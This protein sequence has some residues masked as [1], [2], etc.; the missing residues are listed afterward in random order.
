MSNRDTWTSKFS[1]VLA[2]IGSAIGLG[3]I[4]MFPWRLGKYGGAAFL[5]PYLLFVFALGSTG[6]IE[7]FALGR[8]QKTG[9][10]GAFTKIFKKKDL[11]FG[12][13]IG[14][15]PV[16]GL[17]G[18]F[19]FYTIVAGWILKYFLL[20][21]SGSF[22]TAGEIPNYF[23]SLA[24]QPES[25]L[26]HLLAIILTLAIVRL[27]VKKGIEKV[28]NFMMPT[29]FVIFIILVIRSLTLPGASAGIRFML[30]P[31][32]SLLLKPI[33]WVMALGQAFF[34]VS[35]GGAAMLVYG[36]YLK[37][38]ADIP[39]AAFNTVVFNTL[40]SFLAAFIIIPAVFAFNLD[41]Q[42][43]PPL[44]FI[45]IPKIF[46]QMTGGYFFG[47]LFFLSIVFAAI[48]S[49]INLMEVPV[50]ALIDQL[51]WS[52]KKSVFTVASLSFLAGI[53]LDLNMK[54]FGQFTD[55]VS[56]YLIPLG[57]VLAAI[58]FF[59]VFGISNAQE[60]IN[61]GAKYPVGNWWAFFAKY[62]FTSVSI[63]VLILGIIYNGIG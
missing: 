14:A 34:T 43:G 45:T 3:N 62:I 46:Q 32:W 2:C 37:E 17:T 26:W 28:N 36:S 7:E 42:S 5:I 57:S 31:D 29:L 12:N 53:P 39:S 21:I 22:Q 10:M 54:F 15:I 52:R 30:V 18:V 11:P 58:T 63:I 9:A 41:P 20:T 55:I 47:V 24:G 33:T 27:G 13:L 4:W 25:I 23:N 49:S 16:L 59:W 35:L 1:F 6:L 19:I 44:L 60:Q 56:I 48:S 8:S 50:E 38:D 51:N 40:S 61:Q